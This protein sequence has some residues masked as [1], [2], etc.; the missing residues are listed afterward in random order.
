MQPSP[1]HFEIWNSPA[2]GE[3]PV[4]L[5]SVEFPEQKD[6]QEIHL[7]WLDANTHR[8]PV[9]LLHFGFTHWHEWQVL[10][11]PNGWS[12]RAFVQEF[13]WGGE[14][15]SNL[16]QRFDRSDARGQMI[17]IEAEWRSEEAGA[18]AAIPK[19]RRSIFHW[20]GREWDDATL[21][22][23]VIGATENTRASTQKIRDKNGWGEVLHS[24]DFPRLR[25]GYWLWVTQRLRSL[26]EANASVVEL[27]KRKIA[28]Y[29]RRAR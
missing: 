20:N 28:A 7:R 19:Y 1:F 29:A 4:R 27:K 21:K 14:G 22:Y 5:N 12:S 10:T 17:V 15:G 23:F 26:K 18:D 8:K 24:D 11:F 6:V 13:L 2:H 16:S 3:V 25:K 9:L